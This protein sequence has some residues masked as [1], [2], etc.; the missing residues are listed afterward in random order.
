MTTPTDLPPLPAMPA[1]LTTAADPHRPEYHYLPP[2]NWINDPN[3]LIEWNGAYH[4]FYQYNPAGGFHGTIHWGHAVSHDLVRW[5]DLPIALAPIP[6]SPDAGGCWSG[7]AVDDNGLPT[8]VYT[9]VFPQAV[10]LATGSA[11]LVTWAKHPA[12]PVIAGP[13]AE[14]QA[15]TGDDFRDPF[16]WCEH[17]RWHMVIGAKNGHAGGLVL[18]YSSPD[19]VQWT[20]EGVL[21]AGD[22][23]KEAPFWTG[24]MWECPNFFPLGG[25]HVLIVAIPAKTSGLLHAIYFAGTFDGT[26]FTPQAQGIVAHGYGHYA[27]QVLRM[28]NGRQVMFGWLIDDRPAEV[29]KA[30]GWAG[31]LSV[32][33]ELSLG[34]DGRLNYAPVEELKRLRGEPWQFRNV[35][36]TDGAPNPLS[37][38]SGD[39]LELELVLQPEPGAVVELGLSQSPAGAEGTRLTFDTAAGELRVEPFGVEH[40]LQTAPLAA[41]PGA[42]LHVRVLL[43]RSVIEV[44]INRATYL[45]SRQYLTRADSRGLTLRAASGRTTVAALEVWELASIW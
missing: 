2:A 12:N 8:L 10:C 19:L 1:R 21:L 45:V 14:W 5:R 3:G 25:Q 23:S 11:D 44:F 18:R 39:R 43:D 28:K 17:D 22:S 42:P 15:A 4:L 40:P 13:P 38:V 30:V 7:C 34:A 20:Y 31:C 27:P 26:T 37:A 16:V 29:G 36:L 35:L 41:A 33:V 9:G 32:P 6:G 24:E